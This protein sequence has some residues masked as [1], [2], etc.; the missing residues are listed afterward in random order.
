MNILS[1]VIVLFIVLEGLNIIILYF[2]PQSN[3]GNGVAV[4][5]A[6]EKSKEHP[7]IHLFIKYLINW[8]AGSKLIF[9]ALL[10]VIIIQ[11][12]ETTL[13]LGIAALIISIATFFWRLYPL[14]RTMDKQDQIS[15]KGYSK[16]LAIMFASFLII[17]IISLSYY[18]FFT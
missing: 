3:K 9:V 7:E 17:F 18:Q 10:I 5:D 13:K 8:I 14:I 12:D 11:G 6:F 16:T 1:L 15:P 4:F 2:F